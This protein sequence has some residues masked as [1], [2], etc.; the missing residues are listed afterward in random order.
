MSACPRRRGRKE[1]QL[2]L[3][4][5]AERQLLENGRIDWEQVQQELWTRYRIRYKNTKSAAQTWRNYK[6]SRKSE[7]AIKD[8]E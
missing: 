8:S 4:E 5:I 2:R 7:F 3:A 6:S 1:G